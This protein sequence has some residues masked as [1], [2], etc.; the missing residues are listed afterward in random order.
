MH[1]VKRI[2]VTGGAGFIGS[3]IVDRLAAEGYEIIILDDLSTGKI[4]NVSALLKNKL[5]KFIKGDI[6]DPEI[7][8]NSIKKCDAVI[9]LA[10][11]T[12]VTRSLR[13]PFIVNDVN[14]NGT[15]N[16]LKNSLDSN[17]K[18]FIFVSS[19]AVYGDNLPPLA[20]VMLPRPLSPYGA[21]KLAG[22]HYCLSF[23]KSFELPTVILRCFNVYGRRMSNNGYAP[24][25]SKFTKN[26]RNNASITIYGDGEQTRDFIHV[27][28]VVEAALLTLRS[29]EVSGDTINIGTGKP[30]SINQL[31]KLLIDLAGKEVRIIR[32]EARTG[33]IR[34][35]HAN[36]TKATGKLGFLPK[37]D[38]KEGLQDT[39]S[40]YIGVESL[41]H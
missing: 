30:T 1:D 8:K 35:S 24:V 9:H 5:V 36:I 7:V 17:V 21:S 16:L 29:Q 12:S 6:R 34:H 38:L 13:E 10:A 27:H 37:V 32:K 19:T 31:V 41:V 40:A 26:I 4:N 22:E 15:L 33:E 3:H 18:K 28:D 14:V 11:I 23:W 20:E 2:L 39:I 25:I